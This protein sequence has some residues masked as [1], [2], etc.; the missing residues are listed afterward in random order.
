MIEEAEVA[1]TTYIENMGNGVK[2]PSSSPS[3]QP[4]AAPTTEEQ[5]K[6][7]SSK[8]TVTPE[9]KDETLKT[10]PSSGRTAEGLAHDPAVAM[11]KASIS[12]AAGLTKPTKAQLEEIRSAIKDGKKEEA[13]KLTVKYYNIDTSGAQEV[14]YVGGKKS[15]QAAGSTNKDYEEIGTGTHNR[16]G[17]ISIEIGDESFQF[18]GKE[19]PEWLAAAIYHESFHAKNHFKPNKPV[20]VRETPNSGGPENAK[21]SQQEL[22]EEIQAYMT[23]QKAA[24]KLG[25]SDEMLKDIN[26]RRNRVYADLTPENMEILRPILRGTQPWP[27]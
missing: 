3:S 16:N 1:L 14:K 9:K 23:E 8:P 19:S 17:K 12:K 13:I 20:F 21:M 10:P 27:Q 22:A 4:I 7:D 25:L 11:R 24:D 6:T 15:E 2:G 18:K 5:N 26:D